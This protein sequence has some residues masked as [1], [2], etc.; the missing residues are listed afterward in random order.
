MKIVRACLLLLLTAPA[1]GLA[2]VQ[3]LSPVERRIVTEV[4]ARA[5]EAIALLERLVNINSGTMN[6][7]GVREVGRI[8][9]EELEALG[10]EVELTDGSGY[11]RA[12]HLVAR[13]AGQ[14]SGPHL[15][16]IGHL[17]TVFEPDSPF[18][19]FVRDGDRADGPGVVDMKGGD[20]V[21][22]H[23]LSALA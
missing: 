20:V 4:D 18:Q 11:D 7:E 3:Q 22:V 8:L 19:T 14:G 5:E 21:I 13:R 15:L 17:D 12:G 16:L 1:A 6:F 2:A 23:A 10:F 9:G